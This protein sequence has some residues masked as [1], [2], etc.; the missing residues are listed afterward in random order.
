MWWKCTYSYTPALKLCSHLLHLNEH[1]AGVTILSFGNA[2]PEMLAN[3]LTTATGTPVLA[4]Y[5]S[6]ALFTTLFTGGLINYLCPFRMNMHGTLRDT[7]FFL[8]GVMYLE[9][10]LSN[11]QMISMNEGIVLL[12]IYFAYL[13]VNVV[14]YV[15][16]RRYMKS[17]WNQLEELVGD[18]TTPNAQSKSQ[19]LRKK[20]AELASDAEMEVFSRNSSPL[21]HHSSIDL[22]IRSQRKNRRI[23][24]SARANMYYNI[25]N[26]WNRHIFRDFFESL[27]PIKIADWQAAK[28]YKRAYYIARVPIAVLTALFIPLVDYDLHKHG[29]S[30]L[31]NCIQLIINPAITVILIKSM[32]FGTK[33]WYLN[34]VQDYIY[35]VYTF[36]LTVPLA[37]VVFMKSRTDAPP[38]FHFA[39]TTLNLTGSAF[40]I[41]YCESEIDHLLQV[42]AMVMHVPTAFVGVTITP[43]A[44]AMGAMVVNTALAFQGYE[45]MAFAACV[46]GPFITVILGTASICMANAVKDKHPRA[47][48]LY[49]EYGMNAFIFLIISLSMTL[50]WTSILNYRSRRSVGIYSL[51]L[52][53]LFLLFAVLIKDNIIHSYA[54]DVIL[55]D[56]FE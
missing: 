56:S 15:L 45:R 10:T 46:G 18:R 31:L 37:I 51:S 35:G 36:A 16:T 9:F 52:Y 47:Q 2:A 41:Y 30:K 17:I 43:V 54:K 13:M 11:D 38:L 1:L 44:I 4:Y 39:F 48:T 53:M 25:S 14:D 29:W 50:M 42:I 55:Q 12:S 8:I 26:N 34:I 21:E 19:V 49:G 3:L 22:T 40:T 32:Y 6:K 20:Y 7:F 28:L 23:T 33:I 24:V 27:A 5:Y